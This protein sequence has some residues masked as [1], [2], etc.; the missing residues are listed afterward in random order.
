MGGCLWVHARTENCIKAC[1]QWHMAIGSCVHTSVVRSCSQDWSPV[2]TDLC[3]K[4]RVCRR[5]SRCRWNSA[6]ICADTCIILGT[7][8]AAD[9]SRVLCAETS[10]TR[11]R[12]AALGSS[13]YKLVRQCAA[14]LRDEGTG[15]A[16]V[17]YGLVY[18]LESHKV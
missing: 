13:M 12:R 6:H 9:S 4:A 16:A 8:V 2:P 10:F 3:H 17:W 18:S 14:R 5:Q 7:G 1:E 15:A 11:H